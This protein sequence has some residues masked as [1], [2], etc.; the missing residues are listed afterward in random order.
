MAYADEMDRMEGH[1]DG[2]E[3][4]DGADEG[5]GD[6]GIMPELEKA[7]EDLARH[8]EEKDWSAAARCFRDAA[9]LVDEE[10]DEEEGDEGHFPLP[11]EKE[12]PGHAALLL[13]P[14]GG[15]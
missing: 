15:K 10:E 3:M 14:H 11:G 1:D 13:M 9:T 7:M 4:Q 8:L 6:D 5:E 12:E 2:A